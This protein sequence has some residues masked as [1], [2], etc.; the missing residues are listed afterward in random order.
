[1]LDEAMQYLENRQVSKNM[2][3]W[4]VLL[5]LLTYNVQVLWQHHSFILCL[6]FDAHFFHASYMGQ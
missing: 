4:K 6:V 2:N 1:M 3:I 5:Y